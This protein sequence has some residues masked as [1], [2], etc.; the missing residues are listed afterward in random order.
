M[1]VSDV[2]MRS[3]AKRPIL[4]VEA[5]SAPSWMPAM[6]AMINANLDTKLTGLERR[7]DQVM[8]IHQ[9]RLDKHDAELGSQ[10]QLLEKLRSEIRLLK[11]EGLS[12]TKQARRRLL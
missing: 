4:E 5:D 11:H 9:V 2:D 10:R 7:M 3:S 1:L 8:G 12:H 6:V